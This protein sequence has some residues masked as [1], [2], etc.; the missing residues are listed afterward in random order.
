VLTRA[1]RRAG[2]LAW[3]AAGILLAV[4]LDACGSASLSG[5][6]GSSWSVGSGPLAVG[7][8]FDT[9]FNGFPVD[10]DG[11]VHVLA[12]RLV[13]VPDALRV[14][15]V[16]AVSFADMARLHCNDTLGAATEAEF[17]RAC[18]T[19]PHH[20]VSDA[21]LFPGHRIDWYFI[22]VVHATRPGTFRTGGFEIDY[23]A[24]GAL[25]R[26]QTYNDTVVVT[27]HA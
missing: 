5:G 14:D 2:A 1:G 27:A 4:A 22:G 6:G 8:R 17:Q 16:Y 18:P 9:G 15:D 13:D 7:T 10:G 24:S 3:A 11:E 26:S 19:L 12:A 23:M 25:P 21:T 20:P